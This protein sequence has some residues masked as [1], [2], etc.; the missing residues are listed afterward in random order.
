MALSWLATHG[1]GWRWRR[2]AAISSMAVIATALSAATKAE[3]P[4]AERPAPPADQERSGRF[5]RIPGP[6]TDKID[7]R[8]RHAVD[9]EV[10]QAKQHGKWPVFVI[11]IG[12]G[13][14]EFGQ[15]YDLARFL[16]SDAL[17]GATTVAFLPESVTG[18]NVLVAMACDEIIMSPTAE[19]GEAGKFESAI[20][21][22]MRNAYAEI[23]NRR[24]TIPADL[25]L[26]MLD[27]SLEVLE[28]ETDVSR[29]FVLASRL[30][31]L[32]RDKA[33]QASKVV[34]PAGKPGLFT[35]QQ[36]RELGFV[37][38]LAAD[39]NDVAKIWR[40]PREALQDDPTLDG[41]WRTARFYVKG[42]ITSESIN[43]L[44]TLLRTEIR[45]Q[46]LNFLCLW[47]DSP[48]G[49][50]TDSMNLANFLAS[51]DPGQQ[52]TV[53]Y[54]PGEARGDAAFIALACDQIVMHPSATLGGAGAADIP[55][56]DVKLITAALEGICKEKSR[57]PAIAAAMIDPNL[58]V[59]RCVR[60]T[61]G[62]VDFM[63]AEQ[64]AARERQEPQPGLWRKEDE[65]T[66]PGSPLRLD[67]YQAEELGLATGVVEN[68]AEFKAMY[69]LEHDPQL[70]EPSW[71]TTLIEALNSPGVSWFLLFLGG[72]A[73]YFELQSPGIG[74]GGIIGAL[75]FLLYFWSAYLGGT[76]GWLEVL[77][78]LSGLV[79]LLLEV[80]VFPGLTI[81]GL[82]GG[83]MVVASL[84]LATQTFVVPHNEYQLAHLRTTLTVVVGAAVAAL[85]A[86]L[87]MNRF[88]PHTPMFNRMLLAPPS[89]D[90]LS[91]ISAREALAQFE[92]LVGQQG[93]AVT[94]LLPSGKARF[95]EVLVDVLA[96]REFI[97]RGK[98]VVVVQARANRVLVRAVDPTA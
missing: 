49:S 92:H 64:L 4:A 22:P 43:R 37:S 24:K 80:F 96:D 63:S 7:Q 14:T 95:G 82:S 34:K 77:L 50:P 21:P 31:E 28:V 10:R 56:D 66:H 46:S 48:G 33:F 65:L 20:G 19:I 8:I 32:R 53:A 59:Y 18:H 71:V 87:L 47:I 55:A 23:A 61:D 93:V 1:Y 84:V 38:Y 57:N 51:L 25:A 26:G 36:G 58:A 35:G 52:R 45:E 69:N 41:Q 62:L 91:Q 90:E 11:E 40:L 83:L 88:L 75:C 17:N 79:C 98:P 68:F 39:R 42:A 5:L 78:F 74:L 60:K 76:A 27:P 2:L 89:A 44:Q 85:G 86:A 6:V 70:L 67:G 72:A 97:E 13:R 12:S 3:Q 9:L 81:F 16:S 73:L 15:A 29:E 54:I 94:P 30:D